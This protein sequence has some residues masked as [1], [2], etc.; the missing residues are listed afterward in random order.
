MI[1]QIKDVDMPAFDSDIK[2]VSLADTGRDRI[3]WALNEMP[4]L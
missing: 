4:L 1:K 2:D 3:E